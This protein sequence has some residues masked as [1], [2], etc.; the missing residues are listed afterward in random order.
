VHPGAKGQLQPC[1]EDTLTKPHLLCQGGCT[2]LKLLAESPYP[3]PTRQAN[4]AQAA[5]QLRLAPDV[6]HEARHQLQALPRW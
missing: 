3:M 4:L 6:Q 5:R 2:V 1:A